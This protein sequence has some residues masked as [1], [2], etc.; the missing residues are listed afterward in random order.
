M[1]DTPIPLAGVALRLGR[2]LKWVHRNI[3][4]LRDRHGFPKPLPGVGLYDPAAIDAWMARQ[5][6]AA[7]VVSGVVT[8][9]TQPVDYAALLDA[10]AAGLAARR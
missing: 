2:S 9:E 8:M 3:R 5:R 4:T 6:G 10:R 7:P 1:V